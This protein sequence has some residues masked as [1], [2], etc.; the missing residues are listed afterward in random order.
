MSK[1]IVFNNPETGIANM[2]YPTPEY[3]TAG[4]TLEKLA[5]TIVPKETE[6]KIVLVSKIKEA[7]KY[8]RDA[9]SWNFTDDKID[10]GMEK[11]QDIHMRRLKYKRTLKWKKMGVPQN[12][13]AGLD[14]AFSDT[15]KKAIKALR[16][17]EGEDLK[18][19]TD[20]E[21]LKSYSPSYL[22]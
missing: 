22:D 11:A 18:K 16:K 2:V 17:L 9:W 3:L 19:F 20:P 1:C 10:I 4:G 6:F 14:E 7:D 21:S 12:I 8:F 15:D 5:K 13:N